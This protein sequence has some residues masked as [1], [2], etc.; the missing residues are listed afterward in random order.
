CNNNL[1]SRRGVIES[2]NF[3]NTYPHN[4]NC[5]WMIQAPRGSNVSIAFSHLFMEG[6][7][8]CDADYVE[9]KSITSDIL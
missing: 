2:P 5:T 3:P 7:Q 6:G 8:T 1:T 9:V 4:H